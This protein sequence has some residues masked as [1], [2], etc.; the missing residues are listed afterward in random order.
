M[1]PTERRK[2]L[3]LLTYGLY[4]ATSRGPEGPAGGT[5]TWLSQS[6]FQP[7]LIMAGIKRDSSLHRAISVS[8]AFAV[9][10][11]GKGQKELAMCFFRDTVTEGDT[12]NRY[13]FESGQ[14]GAPILVDPPAWLECR[15]V[16]E[17]S[18][19]DH[20]IFVAEV[21]A[22][23]YRRDEEPLTLHEAGFTYGG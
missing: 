14:T 20:S 6:S 17:I 7:P 3:R 2:A 5:I 16:D 19:G 11:V 12:M 9:H 18:R 10:V 15:V 21:V 22:A 8:R 23:G 4:V 13:R 1:D